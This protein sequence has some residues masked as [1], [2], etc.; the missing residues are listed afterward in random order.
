MYL[1]AYIISGSVCHQNTAQRNTV[2]HKKD[3]RKLRRETTKLKT[4]FFGLFPVSCPPEWIND[5]ELCFLYKGG[6]FRFVEAETYCQVRTS[7][8]KLNQ[9]KEN[10]PFYSCWQR[11]LASDWQR[12]F[13][14]RPLCF[15]CANQ[16]I[17]M[18]TS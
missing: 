14:Y 13:G 6:S 12:G 4:F 9:L 5:N 3:Q 8:G 2:R 1:S 18:L 7:R 10:R 16:V 15:Y 11:D 17:L